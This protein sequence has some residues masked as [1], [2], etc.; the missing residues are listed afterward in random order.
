[1]PSLCCIGKLSTLLGLFVKQR[2]RIRPLVH[3]VSVREF[4]IPFLF[5]PAR[6]SKVFCSKNHNSESEGGESLMLCFLRETGR[7]AGGNGMRLLEGEE[8]DYVIK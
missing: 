1:M 8:Y 7:W 6:W 4:S 5:E 3:I 2:V